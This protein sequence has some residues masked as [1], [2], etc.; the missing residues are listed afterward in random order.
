MYLT[1]AHLAI[2]ILQ[3]QPPVLQKALVSQIK[4]S[5]KLPSV[6]NVEQLV[7]SSTVNQQKK[8]IEDMKTIELPLHHNPTNDNDKLEDLSMDLDE[9]FLSYNIT[10]KIKMKV[11]DERIQF[12]N[13]ITSTSGRI[14]NNN[15]DSIDSNKNI[16]KVQ[17]NDGDWFTVVR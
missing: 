9:P 7:K 4:A 6:N 10:N 8:T 16:S 12:P 5:S 1:T 15:D 13:N 11:N 14:T 3:N 17:V 2:S